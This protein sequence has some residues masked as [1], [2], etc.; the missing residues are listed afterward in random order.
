MEGAGLSV[1]SSLEQPVINKIAAARNRFSRM[2]FLDFIM[3]EVKR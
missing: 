3:V 2:I 1:S